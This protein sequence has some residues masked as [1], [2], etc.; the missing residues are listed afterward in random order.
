MKNSISDSVTGRRDAIKLIA[1]G[2]AAD[3][4]G[5]LGSPFAC[6]EKY[7]TPDYAKVAA[8]YPVNSKSSLQVRTNDGTLIRL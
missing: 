3:L 5:I 1:A 6:A 7:E 8:K 4:F 2:S